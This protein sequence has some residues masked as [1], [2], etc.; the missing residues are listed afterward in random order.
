MSP[1]DIP[2]G[3]V[4]VVGGGIAGCA[5]CLSLGRRGIP[6][7]LIAPPPPAEKPGETLAA[8]ALPLLADLE[9][10][11]LL[12]APSHRPATASFTSWGTSALI[13]QH[14]AARPEG[15]GLILDR[16]R[17]EADLFDLVKRRG[18]QRIE[19]ALADF[20]RTGAGWTLTTDA[21]DVIPARFLIDA[22]GRR[23]L[24]GRRTGRVRR[25]DRLVAACTVL[26][27]HDTGIDPTPATL[28]EAVDDGWW[29]AALLAD[30]RLVVQ[31]Y[32]DPDL[33]PRGLSGNLDLW[34][35]MA[36][37]T[38]YISQWIDSAGYA[39]TEPPRLAPAGT[40]WLEESAGPD[41][42]A[43]GDAAAAFD[44][45]SA[46]GMT[47]ALWTGLH[48]ANAVTAAL[49]GDL[50]ELETYAARLRT[51]VERFSRGRVDVYAR[52]ARFHDRPF[53]RRRRSSG[54]SRHHLAASPDEVGPQHERTVL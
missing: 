6:V 42:L 14:A 38:A 13:E 24:I 51:G 36:G 48:G 3:A 21:G 50:S 11:H 31:F 53:W 49:G 33:I 25:I 23:A 35:R 52:E 40:S 29:Y 12:T 9:A 8:A 37:Q 5:A 41:W 20:R 46:H 34:R 1:G 16:G 7:T 18:I 17:F 54:L 45:L 19:A 26:T 15:L 39:L 28:I 22:T 27:Q 32:S 43:V 10:G 4:A 44:P 30:R 2:D 47:T